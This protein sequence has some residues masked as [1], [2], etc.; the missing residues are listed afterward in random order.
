MANIEAIHR[1]TE[2]HEEEHIGKVQEFLRQPSISAENLGVRSECP[3]FKYRSLPCWEI[4]KGPTA[5]FTITGRKA[6]APISAN[7]AGST[8]GGAKTSQ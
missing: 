6:M 5:N 7:T 8:R 1:Y 2:E 3:A 4:E